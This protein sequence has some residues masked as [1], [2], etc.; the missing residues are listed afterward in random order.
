[1][2]AVFYWGKAGL[3][4]EKNNP[5]GPLLARAMA[6][7]GV[8]LEAGYD[9][10]LSE[11]WLMENRSRVDVL[12]LNWPSYMYNTDDAGQ[13]V[14][15][16]AELIGH[17]TLA[18]FLGYRVVWTVHNLYPHERPHPGLDRLARLAI[19]QLATALIV[20]C[21]YGRVQV[22]KHFH[23]THGIFTVPHGHFI[24]V[25]ENRVSRVAARRELGIAPDGF[26]YLFFGNVKR[27]KGVER[28][29]EVFSRLQGEHLRLLLAAKVNSEY[30]AD[31][32][33]RAQAGDP[34]ILMHTAE[35]FPDEELQLFFNAADVMVLPFVDMLTSGSA[36]TAMS[37]ARPVIAPGIGCLPELLDENSGIIYDASNRNGLERAMEEIR[38]RDMSACSESAFQRAKALSWASIAEK[39]LEAYQHEPRTPD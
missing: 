4:F 39:T 26:V 12:H 9:E 14:K 37:F 24:D 28:L 5:Y 16:C 30:S 2:R 33:A 10:D 13:S 29:L 7:I 22:L 20:H 27:Y 34:R 23:R 1:M 8:A 21:E 3:G 6:G 35:F 31:V 19:T 36:I 11:S 17:L 25:Y 15:K 32:V 18:R 38:E